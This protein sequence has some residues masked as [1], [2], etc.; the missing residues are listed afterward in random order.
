MT[1]QLAIPFLVAVGI[2]A[3]PV[4][5]HAT[6][7]WCAEVRR[8]VP[9]GFLNLR[10]G[11]STN[12]PVLARLHGGEYIEIDTAICAER[13]SADWIVTGTICAEAGSSWGLV[14]YSPRLGGRERGG[15]INTQ[16]VDA[17]QCRDLDD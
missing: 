6:Q 2:V 12:E 4:P 14:E 5:T 8:D 9:D 17:L 7:A 1:K 13:F 11:P 16:Y 3:G 10:G 15:W